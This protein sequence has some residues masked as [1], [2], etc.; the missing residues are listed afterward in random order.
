M[1]SIWNCKKSHLY[2]NHWNISAATR[3][4]ATSNQHSLDRSRP[5][6]LSLWPPRRRL[7]LL[8]SSRSS[9]WT[10]RSIQSRQR[11]IRTILRRRLL[12]G[13][14]SQDQR[15]WTLRRAGRTLV[16]LWCFASCFVF[17]WCWNCRLEI[18]KS[19]NT[20]PEKKYFR[21]CKEPYRNTFSPTKRL[22]HFQT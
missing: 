17:L 5:P 1:L 15:N 22:R 7:G 3:T 13:W 21:F 20:F 2:S 8:R 6:Q 19:L 4:I 18:Y 14:L 9:K 16:S 12:E 11:T 10:K